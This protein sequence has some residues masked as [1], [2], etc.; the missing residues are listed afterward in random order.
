MCTFTLSDLHEHYTHTRTKHMHRFTLQASSS[1]LLSQQAKVRNDRWTKAGLFGRPSSRMCCL[2][3]LVCYSACVTVM[4][5]LIA[6]DWCPRLR[7]CTRMFLNIQVGEINANSSDCCIFSRCK[8]RSVELEVA[9]WHQRL[10]VPFYL[11]I[12]CLYIYHIYMLYVFSFFW[13]YL[14]L[15]VMFSV[16][17]VNSVW[18]YSI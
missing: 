4:W 8:Q 5:Q 9:L 6:E 16:H 11:L 12:Y 15:I 2:L 7:R 10:R 17:F 1:T 13:S 14:S 18:W 3:V